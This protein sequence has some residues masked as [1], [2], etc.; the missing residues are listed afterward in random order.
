KQQPK[1]MLSTTDILSII[2]QEKI[3]DIKQLAKQLEIQVE[4]LEKILKDLSKHN[5][6]EYN[7]QMGKVKISPWLININKEIEDLKPT[8]GTIILPKNQEIKLQDVTI[9]NFTNEDLELNVKLKAKRKEI[10]ICEIS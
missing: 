4:Q 2:E 8:T 3:H 10:A 6:V 5:L 7:Q 9:G 1:N